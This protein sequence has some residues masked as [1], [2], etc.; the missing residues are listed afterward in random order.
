MPKHGRRHR[1][2]EPRNRSVRS[3]LLL[4]ISWAT[5][6][7][8]SH[9]RALILPLAALSFISILSADAP[10]YSADSLVNSADNQSGWLA[11]NA[12]ATLYGRNLA[13]GTKTL[14]SDDIRGGLLPTV[15][16]TP[17]GGVLVIGLPPN[18]YY[19]SPT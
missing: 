5:R 16:P 7:L 4:R 8:R 19:V 11:P 13:Y 14:T 1:P 9:M 18:P 12:I 17:G 2:L 10:L 15:L 6:A 3:P